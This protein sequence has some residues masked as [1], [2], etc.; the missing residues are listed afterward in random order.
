MQLHRGRWI[1]IRFAFVVLEMFRE[2][3]FTTSFSSPSCLALRF[4]AVFLIVAGLGSATAQS[5]LS[6]PEAAVTFTTID[7]PGS[8][9]TAV[10]AINLAG[11]MVG[12]YGQRASGATG[13]FLLSNGTF[14]YLNYPNQAVTVPSGINDSGLIVGYATQLASQRSSVVGFVYDGTTF[15]A[16]TDGNNQATYGQGI[17]NVGTIV[18]RFGSLSFT[19]GFALANG[20]YKTVNFPGQYIYGIANAINNNG[21]VVGSADSDAYTYTNGKSRKIDV[22]GAQ[23]TAATGVNDGGIIV[24]YYQPTNMNVYYGFVM[25][26]RRMVSLKYPGALATFA[27]GINNGGQIVGAY[28]FDYIAYHGFVTTPVS[29]TALQ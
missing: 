4:L 23:V 2:C 29:P 5:D 14:T 28:T 24:G 22:P 6:L 3:T 15:S 27:F 18:G 12:D 21:L 7:V 11:D 17:N 9:V 1:L 10:S 19:K 26:N 8:V 25:L 20:V 16:L 13:G